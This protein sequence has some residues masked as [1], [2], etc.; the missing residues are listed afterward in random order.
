MIGVQGRD[1]AAAAD[2]NRLAVEGVSTPV[3]SRT[4][5]TKVGGTVHQ[6]GGIYSEA[7]RS[8]FLS[9]STF[10]PVCVT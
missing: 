3:W 4:L 1:R 9:A 5:S 7:L 8:L 10:T 2:G 6:Q